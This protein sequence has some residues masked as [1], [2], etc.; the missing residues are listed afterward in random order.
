M[1]VRVLCM[2]YCT[3]CEQASE[4]HASSLLL[5]WGTETELRS[6]S[7]VASILNHCAILLATSSILNCI[8]LS[9]HGF[10]MD[11]LIDRHERQR[12]NFWLQLKYLLIHN[13]KP[14]PLSVVLRNYLR[15]ADRRAIVSVL[16]TQY[17][18]TGAVLG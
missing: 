9:S 16:Y 1:C 2:W 7:L 17:P 13:L 6:S 15:K 10:P 8:N 4:N 5:L 12:T 18:Q 3:V 11:I 14:N